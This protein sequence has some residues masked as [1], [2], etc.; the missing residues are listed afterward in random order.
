MNILMVISA[1]K[2]MYLIIVLPCALMMM[3][4]APAIYAQLLAMNIIIASML[5]AINI[6]LAA[7][8]AD[9]PTKE[10]AAKSVWNWLNK[11][12]LKN[13]RHFTRHLWIRAQ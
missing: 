5:H 1:V 8:L 11:A 6:I 13:A 10:P 4:S 3:Y 9:K 7:K 2:T 12:K